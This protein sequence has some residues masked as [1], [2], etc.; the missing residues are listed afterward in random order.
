MFATL[1]LL[2]G[3]WLI[4]MLLIGVSTLFANVEYLA[5]VGAWCVYISGCLILIEMFVLF[6]SK[7]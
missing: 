4:G 5:E 1:I 3:V 7:L 6:I 2:I